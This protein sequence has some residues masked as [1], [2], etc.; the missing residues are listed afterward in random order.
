LRVLRQHAARG[1]R[2]FKP[3]LYTIAT[4]LAR[5]HF[6]SSAT[7]LSTRLE[8]EHEICVA[9]ETPGPEEH[10]LQ[11]ERQ[12]ALVDALN[13]LSVEYWF[14][15]ITEYPGCVG[16][17]LSTRRRPVKSDNHDDLVEALRELD[18][19]PAETTAWVPIV[20]QLTAWPDRRITPADKGHLMSVLGQ[21]MPQRSVVRQAIHERLARQNRLVTL[22]TTAHSQV[23]MLR[24][25]FWMLSAVIVL[26]GAIIELSTRNPAAIAWLRALAPLLAFLSV[27]SVFR[28]VGLRTLEWELA[29]PPSAL[30]LIMARLV[31]VLGYD[32]CL[33]LILSLI[34]WAHGGSFLV[35]TLYWLVPF[36]LVAGLALTLSL[37]LPVALAAALAYCSWVVLLFLGSG[38][39]NMLLS[40]LSVAFIMHQF[41]PASLSIPP[42]LPGIL[43][44]WAVL[45]LPIVLILSSISFS[46]GTFWPRLSLPFKVALLLAWFLEAPIINRIG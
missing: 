32:A 18:A 15:A 28:G 44:L 42:D 39:L 7:R 12:S 3:W 21:E 9:D 35:V 2:P 38:Q 24:F 14:A 22:L 37:W 19:T 33:G 11:V 8:S 26:L 41:R 10:A 43:T 25:T 31:V 4:N 40:I 30:Q 13:L 16:D 20:Q 5:D 6:K 23:S 36:L 1:D 27:A 17:Y 45:F 29:C 46:L 34:G